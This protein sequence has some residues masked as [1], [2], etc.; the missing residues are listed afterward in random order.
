M[1]TSLDRTKV[2][3]KYPLFSKERTKVFLIK[4]KKGTMDLDIK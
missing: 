3:L 4:G 2:I 1:L